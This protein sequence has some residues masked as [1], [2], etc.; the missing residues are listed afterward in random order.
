MFIIFT[1]FCPVPNK[2]EKVIIG[3]NSGKL[4]IGELKD[5]ATINMKGQT[6]QSLLENSIEIHSSEKIGTYFTLNFESKDKYPTI[7][8]LICLSDNKIVGHS[9]YGDIFLIDFQDD[10]FNVEIIREGNYNRNNR[11]YNI[12]SINL[13]NFIISGNYGVFWLYNKNNEGIWEENEKS[14]DR[15]AHF[16]LNVY[17]YESGYYIAN[18]YNGD[19]R[20][21]DKFGS[22]LFELN[23]FNSNLQNMVIL[24]DLI[25][26]VD[27]WSNSHVYSKSELS[28][29]KYLN[30]QTIDCDNQ[31]KVYPKVVF[32]KGFFYAAFPNK[33][34]RFD[35]ELDH[36]QNLSLK[37]KDI[38]IID[39]NIVI[40]T[41]D[42]LFII[43]TDSFITPEDYIRY[44]Y[45][46]AGIVGYTATGKSTFCYK[47]IYDEYKDDLGTTSGT[48]TWCL[49]FDDGD[50]IFI[51]DIPGQHDEIEFYFPKLKDCDIIIGMCKIKDSIKPWKETIDLC[52]KI[53]KKYNIENFIFIRSMSDDTEKAPRTAIVQ[54]LERKGFDK[55]RLFD[56]S[57]KQENGGVEE[58]I[59]L[60]GQPI[61]WKKKRISTENEIK[62]KLISAIGEARDS[63]LDKI[64]LKHF[65]LPGFEDLNPNILEK[66]IQKVADEGNVY[67]IPHTKEIIFNTEKMGLVQS[68]ILNLFSVSEGLINE[69]F[70]ITEIK[71]KFSEIDSEEL[72]Y[73]YIE[74]IGYLIDEHEVF[75][76]LPS[77][78]L[79]KSQLKESLNI[80]ED[81]L[82]TEIKIENS[83]QI[84]EIIT[85]FENPLVQ[86]NEVTK[87]GIKFTDKAEGVIFIEFSQ[88]TDF[89][90]NAS[91]SVFKIYIK[92]S[93]IIEPFFEV[94]Y[95][96]L[97]LQK[98][99]Y[100]PQILN[101]NKIS[102]DNLENLY[103]LFNF[104]DETPVIDFK[105][106]LNY[107]KGKGKTLS[108]I[109]KE[110][111]KDIIAL[112]NSS[113]L[114]GN[115][116]YLI[117]GL[118][119][120][121]G[122]FISIREIKNHSVLFQQIAFLCRKYIN[123][124]FNINPISLRINEVYNMV[125]SGKIVKNI[126]FTP[127]Q[128]DPTCTEKIMV[129]QITREPKE[130]LELSQSI[131]WLSKKGIK[132]IHKGKSWIR[133]GSHTFDILNE[134]RK[135]LFIF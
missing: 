95:E 63:K 29:K 6:H 125:N 20:I 107:Q 108:R 30:I 12:A 79:I 34:W 33:L 22:E 47:M 94:L 118:E 15:H 119:E 106:E 59:D 117:F 93:D 43:N 91:C 96:K 17:D 42:N 57:A 66:F 23:G 88:L 80:P 76:I 81:L 130:C 134:E 3:D 114:Y 100:L 24:P 60:L 40:L 127:I 28:E 39:D 86:L 32:Y 53:R 9:D 84:K 2:K 14:C 13:D 83:I 10:E 65:K 92:N 73:Y 74:F 111:L 18:N 101:F 97:R 89:N 8:N 110:I 99:I 133:V 46:K 45:L 77:I 4:Y 128:E 78:F 11:M 49:E 67:Y 104:P 90:I 37:C 126:P 121:N 129:I 1:S 27:Y 115:T 26:A 50:K 19:T 16:A 36:I 71:N 68:Y 62:T 112:G 116:A 85:L 48:L 102:E 25:V 54:Y 70:V 69:E 35:I 7:R 98:L 52:E 122:N 131:S 5:L 61:Y 105:R 21:L 120:V 87:N 56:V 44:K 103:Y 38:K 124:C 82:C 123:T 72:K 64:E 51:K 55:N 109:Q 58:I 41:S 135:K 132:T 31:T 75:E 113:Y